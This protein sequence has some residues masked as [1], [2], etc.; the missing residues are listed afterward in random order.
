VEALSWRV[1]NT[2]IRRPGLPSWT[3]LGWKESPMSN[4]RR[5][6]QVLAYPS[7]DKFQLCG[8]R[9]YT[10]WISIEVSVEAEYASGKVLGWEES[11]NQILVMSTTLSHPT[12]LRISGW[13]FHVR[14]YW[15]ESWMCSSPPIFTS[16][17]PVS[18]VVLPCLGFPEDAHTTQDLFAIV[19]SMESQYFIEALLF[20]RLELNNAYERVGYH[21]QE[22]I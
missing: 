12:Y 22:L 18:S 20:H 8:R 19:V 9:N 10:Q 14:I 1:S 4:L 7:F 13:T 21:R 3:W 16:V 17:A 11:H 15:R 2:S 6:P 5:K